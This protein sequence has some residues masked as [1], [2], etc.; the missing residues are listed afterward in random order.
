[1][2]AQDYNRERIWGTCAFLGNSPCSFN[3]FL[4]K[5]GPLV[6]AL[7]QIHNFCIDQNELSVF[8]VP[9]RNTSNLSGNY[10]I[11][12][13]FGSV[14]VAE[15]VDLDVHGCPISLL[16]HCHHFADAEKNRRLPKEGTP[17]DDMIQSVKENGL[18]CLRAK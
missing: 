7:L 5:V 15:I 13:L 6:E 14:S 12:Q 10:E 2:Y 11:S 3:Y 8:D 9:K 1:M 4:A 16:G 17:M 18:T